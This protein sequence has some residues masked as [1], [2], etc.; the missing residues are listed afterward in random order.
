MACPASGITAF[1]SSTEVSVRIL[2][3]SKDSCGS[4]YR[5][6]QWCATQVRLVDIG[7]CLEVRIIKP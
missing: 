6:Q 1:S 3:T 4:R 5:T 7:E 2:L